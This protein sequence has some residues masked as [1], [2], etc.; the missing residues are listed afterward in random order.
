MTGGAD[1]RSQTAGSD[2]LRRAL[3]QMLVGPGAFSRATQRDRVLRPYQIDPAQAVWESVSRGLGRQFAFVFS[4]Q[5]GK[6]ELLAQLIAFLLIRFQARGGS[7]VVATPALRPQGIVSRDRLLNAL[8]NPVTERFTQRREGTSVAV[9]K[10]SAR[11]ISASPTANAR[12]Q[13]ADLLLV[14]N[15]AQ[16]IR[17]E[18]WDAVFDPMAA[19]TNATTLFLGT[20]WSRETLLARQMRHLEELE[21]TDGI[22]RLFRVN[23]ETVAAIVPA[24]GERVRARIAQFGPSHPFI[25]TE[26]FLEELDGDGSLFPPQRLAQ[27]QGDHFRRHAAEAG[28]RYA[29]LIDVG[30]EEESGFGLAAFHDLGRRDSTAVTVVEIADPLPGSVL[31]RYLIVDR[32][33]WTGA[34][35][36]TLLPQLT[37]L[38]RSVW[39]ARA[40]VIDATGVGAGLASMLGAALGQRHDRQTPIRVLPFH[41]TASSKSALGWDLLGLIESGRLKEYAET[42]A[43]ASPAAL[44]TTT[45]HEQL[46]GIT[47]DTVP[48]PG[49]QLRWGA[50]PGRHDDL[51]LSLALVSALDGFDW[52][53]RTAR[54]S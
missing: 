8:Q 13:T 30:G 20:V 15:E 34:S 28:K 14:A 29:L 4:R 5:S 21:A 33:A 1:S 22:K 37:D 45:F 27:L 10:A 23:W 7:I 19:S 9:G 44:L 32:I 11:F 47:Y 6:D 2:E 35:H 3:R 51:V 43:P 16:D 36:A 54:G 17:P 25:R 40:V 41:F 52:R 42:A 26:Y 12:G 50:P 31:P 24:Y 49:R 39:K 46:R 53:E 18:V 48:G 38:A